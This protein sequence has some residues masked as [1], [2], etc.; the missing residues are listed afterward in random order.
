MKKKLLILGAAALLLALASKS[1]GQTITLGTTANFALFSTNGAVSNTSPSQVTGNVGT[2]NGSS[3]AFGNVNGQMHDQDGASAQAAAD[4]LTCY[5]QLNGTAA[6]M[7]PAPLMGNGQVLTPGVYSI[8]SAATLNLG[9]TLDAQNNPNAIFLI[10]IQGSLSTNASA[11]VHLINRAMAC[12]VYWQIE[13]LVSMASG[14]TMRGNIIS[15]NGAISINTGDTLEGRALT[16]AGAVTIS[17]ALVYTPIG[18][19]SPVLTGPAA[20]TMGAAACYAIF[21]GNGSVTNTGI[22]HVVGDVGTNVGSTTGY[23]AL[24]VTGTIH[25]GPDGSTAQCAADLMTAY[26]YL[27]TLPYDIE[28]LYPTQFGSNLVLTPH[29]YYMNGACTLTDTVILNAENVSTAVFVIQINGALGTSTYSKIK[30]INGAQAKNV[31]WKIEGA[32]NINNYSVFCGTIV[33]HNGA[34]GAIN[35]GVVLN[36]QALT[37]SGALTTD[38]VTITDQ[39]APGNCASVGMREQMRAGGAI[40]F[41][42]PFTGNATLVLNGDMPSEGMV[43]N[44]YNV[45]GERVMSTMLFNQTTTVST[46][47]LS[48]GI[49]FYE[50]L[51]HGAVIQTGKLISEQ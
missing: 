13:G 6:T 2:N 33:S 25:P 46:G 10:K 34:L 44:M 4:L 9:L 31:Y 36:G 3:T 26:N 20:P 16:T 24:T 1:F 19:G 8:A 32:V 23:N 48:S 35:T 40:V 18:C 43:W 14:T 39:V 15:N 5:N 49:Y 22:T 51:S 27:N 42:N 21:S 30:L 11:K 37:T 7:F 38:A 41:P 12:N 47:G 17:N 29:T 45:L 28:L 50:L